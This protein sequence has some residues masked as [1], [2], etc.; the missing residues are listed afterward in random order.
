MVRMTVAGFFIL[1][2]IA[3]LF[4]FIGNKLVVV[5]MPTGWLFGQPFR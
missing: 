3:I 2:A 5:I 1:L 4:R